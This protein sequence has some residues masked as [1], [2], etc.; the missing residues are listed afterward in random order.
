MVAPLRWL[1]GLSALLIMEEMLQC[2]LAPP[3]LAL[4]VMCLWLLEVVMRALVEVPVLCLGMVRCLG[5]CSSPLAPPKQGPVMLR[6]FQV[7][8]HEVSR[9]LFLLELEAA[10][11][12]QALEH[13]C[14]PAIAH[15]SVEMEAMSLLPQG[16]RLG[17]RLVLVALCL[18]P[19]VLLLLAMGAISPFFQGAPRVTTRR[20]GM[21]LS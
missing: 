12:P 21:C 4:V 10:A 19:P 8:R 15:I 17:R 5:R 13:L 1:L 11:A 9:V 16:T 6:L 7:L 18:S 2:L 20:L 3:L 14:Q